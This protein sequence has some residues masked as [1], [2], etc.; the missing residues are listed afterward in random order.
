[1]LPP[2][3]LVWLP[4]FAGSP[5]LSTAGR[6][7]LA[8][9]LLRLQR[10]FVPALPGAETRRGLPGHGIFTWR[11]RD[12][13]VDR[14]I[15]YQIHPDAIVVVEVLPARPEFREQTY[16]V[17]RRLRDY[18]AR[19]GD[20]AG[21]EWEE[22]EVGE[23]LQ[24]TREQSVLVNIRVVLGERLRR[25]R[26]ARGWTQAGLASAL[27]TSRARITKMEM[28]DHSVSI[29]AC[30][31]SLLALGL[32]QHQIGF[33]I[34]GPLRSPK[35]PADDYRRVPDPIP[36]RGSLEGTGSIE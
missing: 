29:D 15:T 6:L 28:G 18:G 4:W 20:L 12:P 31:R 24:L 10:R 2:L 1:M 25:L 26:W 36:S 22:G 32:S 17:I 11:I 7:R 34:A 5:P 27:G 23:F 8:C 33:T 14:E 19:R 35:R 9:A 30:I 16:P 21:S 13:P 3:R